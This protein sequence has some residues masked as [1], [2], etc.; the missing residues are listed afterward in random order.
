MAL[1]EKEKALVIVANAIS[2]Y[3]IY[4]KNSEMLPKG[5]SMIDFVLKCTPADLRKE[6]SIELIDEVFDFVSRTQAQLS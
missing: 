1:S 6:I 5:I 4:A 2:I 3:S